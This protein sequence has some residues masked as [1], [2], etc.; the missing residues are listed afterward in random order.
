MP[1]SPELR[2]RLRARGRRQKVLRRRAAA[3]AVTLFLALWATIA[4]AG[5]MG[6]TAVADVKTATKVAAHTASS[7]AKRATKSGS[8]TAATSSDSGSTA[9]A[10]S[11]TTTLTTSQS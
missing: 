11:S 8:T 2:A 1:Q 10:A 5:P 7:S 3:S 4:L 9:S 6:S